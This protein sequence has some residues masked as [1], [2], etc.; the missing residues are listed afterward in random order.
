MPRGPK[1]ELSSPSP[2]DRAMNSRLFGLNPSEFP[3]DFLWI[4][5]DR[6]SM[7]RFPS[8]AFA[9]SGFQMNWPLFLAGAE[10]VRLLP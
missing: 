3:G 2:A 4:S 9:P 8:T 5:S 6:R 10:D 7:A 1:V